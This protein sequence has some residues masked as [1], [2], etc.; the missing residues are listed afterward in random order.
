MEINILKETNESME[1]EIV[2]EGHTFCNV[3][4]QEL[5]NVEGVNFASY[6]LKHP[7][8]GSPIFIVNLNKG[9][10]KKALL[11]GA[12]LLKEKTNEMRALLKKLN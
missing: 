9:K 7:T 4:R 5:F 8:I 1:L 6:N 3:L 12:N 10:P 11:D 2:G